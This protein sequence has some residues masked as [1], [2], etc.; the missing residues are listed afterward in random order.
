[1]A[2]AVVGAEVAVHAKCYH[3]SM[4]PSVYVE[5]TV[6]SYLT[7]APSRDLVVAGHQQLTRE[8]WN[9]HLPDFEPYVS[10]AVMD[11][12]SRG[13]PEMARAR[14]EAVAEFKILEVQAKIR[15]L[16][17]AYFERIQLPERARADS[18]HLAFA[19]W[20]GMDF[21]ISWNCKHIASGFVRRQ[22][23]RINLEWQIAGPTICTPEEL[24]EVPDA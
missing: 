15:D 17:D 23:K 1:M 5:T 3:G 18:Y 22:A 12:I 9:E 21:L 13:D 8:W 4:K 6:I 10:P 24:M 19:A 7:S 2:P 20:H 11:E 16:A 14:L